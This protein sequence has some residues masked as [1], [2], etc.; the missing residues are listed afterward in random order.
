MKLDLN[1]EI[2]N[3][4]YYC[5]VKKELDPLTLKAYKIDLKQFSDFMD[6]QEGLLK[7][8]I[9][10]YIEF[11]HIQYKPK[12]T[13]RKIASLKAFYHYLEIEEIIDTSPFH[14]IQVRFREP[15]IL[16]KTIP[17]QQITK[18]L[19][20]AYGCQERMNTPYQKSCGIRNTALLELLFATGLRVSE[21]SHIKLQDINLAD[22]TI[23]VLGKGSKERII[24]LTN[25]EVMTALV[26]Y[27]ALRNTNQDDIKYFF[28]N[29]NGNR[30]SEQSIRNMIKEYCKG[31]GILLHITPHMFR[32]SFATLLLEEDVDI[33]FIQH[34]LGHSSI[35]TTQ[36]YTHVSMN[37]QKWVLEHHHPRNKLDLKI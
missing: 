27:E 35:T 21:L 25:A 10:K 13:K 28:V 22:G 12:T 3:Y 37:K 5:K 17:I 15:F 7:D 9:N 11:L 36:I 31:A 4:L 2:E 6:Y 32:H 30:Y 26:K 24:Q 29:R 33:R 19:M 8:N 20:Y 1:V 16:P 23:R 34:I 14:K 18:L